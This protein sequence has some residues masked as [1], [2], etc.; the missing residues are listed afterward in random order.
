MSNTNKYCI[1]SITYN[2]NLFKAIDITYY[3]NA[4][5]GNSNTIQKKISYI[6]L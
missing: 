5:W 6:I 1:E 4:N 2:G 3:K